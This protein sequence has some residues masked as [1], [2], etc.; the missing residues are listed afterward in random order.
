MGTSQNLPCRHCQLFVVLCILVNTMSTITLQLCR[1]VHAGELDSPDWRRCRWRESTW[2]ENWRELVWQG[3]HTHTHTHTSGDTLKGLCLWAA[4]T[5]C[6]GGLLLWWPNEETQTVTS[7]AG[8]LF[9]LPSNSTQ[10][11]GQRDGK[12]L[13]FCKEKPTAGTRNFLSGF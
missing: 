6:V 10:A 2:R 9:L 11:W 5:G 3:T 8:W 4:W 1:Q 12:H 13:T 7:V